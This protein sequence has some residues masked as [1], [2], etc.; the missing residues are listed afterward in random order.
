MT[1]TNDPTRFQ[2]FVRA[3][4]RSWYFLLAPIRAEGAEHVPATG[5]AI[6]CANHQSLTDPIGM[7]ALL[8]RWICFMAK[9]E[10]F[11]F[12]PLGA[13]VKALG[14]FAVDRGNNDLASLRTAMGVLKKGAVLGIFPQGRRA[15]KGGNEFH[16]GV[17]L[18]ALRSGAPV[19]P[20][21]LPNRTRFFRKTRMIIGPPV[22]LSA[23]SSHP[24][25]EQ[26]LEATEQI[27]A[28]VYAL[29]EA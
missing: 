19:I 16:A 25:S 13:L 18:I 8:D 3:L 23:F 6:L 1:T 26:L 20:I 11:A 15:F 5:A 9:K 10:L 27:R 28:A 7:V 12:P 17:A 4:V 14:A 21:Y 24:S 2:R 22:D 29:K